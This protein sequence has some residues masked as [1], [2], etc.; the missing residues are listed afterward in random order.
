MRLFLDGEKLP[1]RG[2]VHLYLAYHLHFPAWYGQ[3]LDALYDCLLDLRE[4]TELVLRN[5]NDPA[6]R[7]VLEDAAADN[8][9]LTLTVEE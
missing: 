1:Y 5:W 4:D 6:L 9:C 8:D 3:N 2:Q 7:Q